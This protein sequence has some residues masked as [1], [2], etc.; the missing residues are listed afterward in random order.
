MQ[1]AGQIA[2]GAPTSILQGIL[3]TLAALVLLVAFVALVRWVGAFLKLKLTRFVVQRLPKIPSGRHSMFKG[4][5]TWLSVLINAVT[6]AIAATALYVCV[7]YVLS[8]FAYT[9][10][11]S[12]TLESG[13][14]T[15][16]L[17]IGK[18][19]LQGIPGL[20]AIAVIAFI[21]KG[22]TH[23]INVVFKSIER[24]ETTFPWIYPDTAAPTRRIVVAMLWVFA[25]V[26]AYPYIPGNE[27]I[28]FKS[29]SVFVGLLVSLGS[30]GVVSQAMN[31]LAITFGRSFKPGD[32]VKIGG[33]EGT[34]SEVTLV[35]TKLHTIRHEEVI[36]PNSVV[37][38]QTT[39][40]YTRIAD[41]RG[42]GIS[43]SVS[44]GYDV[45]WRQV[46][47]ILMMA[48]E[49]TKG[50]SRDP[51]PYIIQTA[52]S[53]TCTEYTLVAH[54]T[55]EPKMVP[56]VKSELRQSI[57]DAF[58]RHGVNLMVPT[59]IETHVPGV[60]PVEQWCAPPAKDD[61]QGDNGQGDNGQ[62]DARQK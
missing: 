44:M 38:S 54:M 2:G 1:A 52:F 10:L 19:V 59:Y 56:F 23:L 21:T 24:G 4:V 22:L 16:L 12:E 49:M 33:V 28:A 9:H 48:A 46:H 25:I 5:S 41:G 14:V 31:G 53:D 7:T 34:V 11:W 62:G 3:K 43:T 37:A 17:N 51:A 27:S 29:I 45:P 55:E 61:G 50:L 18:T 6:F 58:N 47:A 60:V 8:C 30:A 40:N 42:V 15:L 20:F 26:V 35:F 36:V 39:Y 57:Q 13:I 32:Y